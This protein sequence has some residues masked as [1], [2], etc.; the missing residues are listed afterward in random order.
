M[1]EA[2]PAYVADIL[3]RRGKL[4]GD[5]W[6]FRGCFHT[7]YSLSRVSRFADHAAGPR[8]RAIDAVLELLAGRWPLCFF[9]YEARRR[10]LKI[11][12]RDEILSA[13]NGAVTPKELGG[14]LRHYT[15]NRRYLRHSIAGAARIDLDGNPCGV[16][17]AEGA[18]RPR[19]RSWRPMRLLGGVGWLRRRLH[20]GLFRS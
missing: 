4:M 8:D 18:R 9:V 19:L 1:W 2:V 13:L 6:V 17:T 3:R 7:C 10:P 12:I 20:C 14:A 15:G 11:G 5:F 16:V